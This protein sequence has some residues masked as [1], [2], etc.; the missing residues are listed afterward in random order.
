MC[1][2]STLLCIYLYMYRVI[3][4]L[5]L[6]HKGLTE[7]PV[8]K[9]NPNHQCRIL[10][11]LPYHTLLANIQI[12]PHGGEVRNIY[13]PVI[14]LITD[15]WEET[16]FFCH[17]CTRHGR[18]FWQTEVFLLLFLGLL[19]CF[20]PRS[21]NPVNPNHMWTETFNWIEFCND[22]KVWKRYNWKNM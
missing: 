11:C 18:I 14:S 2:R 20:Q 16:V 21:D 8:N 13:C 1:L 19:L 12:R 7:H 17:V 4:S 6:A 22:Y 15:D 3:Y 9:L 10:Q 5:L